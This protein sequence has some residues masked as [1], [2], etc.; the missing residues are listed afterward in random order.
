MLGAFAA[1][2]GWDAVMVV[3]DMVAQTL[4]CL[5]WTWSCSNVE[6]GSGHAGCS[7]HSRSAANLA[8][9]FTVLGQIV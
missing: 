8:V 4:P 2:S 9:G 6:V 1:M 7:G 3:A 5:V